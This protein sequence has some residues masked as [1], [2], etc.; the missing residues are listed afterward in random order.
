MLALLVPAEAV[1]A[2]SAA[3]LRVNFTEVAEGDSFLT[4]N[5][6]FTVVD[7]DGKVV[8]NASIQS[9]EIILLDDNSRYAAT[10]KKAD[11]PFYIVLVLDASGSMARAAADLRNAAAQSI[12]NAPDG[13]RFAVVMFNDKI[14]VLQDFTDDEERIANAI[15]KVIPVT[16]A[17]T[18]LYDA[19]YPAIDLLSQT[20]AGRRAV[21]VFT[22]GKD[23]TALRGPCSQ[24]T[25]NDVIDHA[26]EVGVGVPVNTIGLAANTSAINATEL[27]GM[28][29]STGGFAVVGSQSGLSEMFKEIMEALGNQW[30]A[31]GALYPTQGKHQAAI[32][33]TLKDGTKLSS[34]AAFESS[35]AYT[36]PANMTVDRV[37]Y[38]AANNIFK[39]S[40]NIGSPQLIDHLR[41]TVW[42]EEKGVQVAEYTV[43]DL[44]AAVTYDIK[45]DGFTSGSDYIFKISALDRNNNLVKN[46]E[47]QDI[48]LEHTVRYEPPEGVKTKLNVVS[49]VLGTQAL[50]ATLQVEGG[51]QV[52]SYEGWLN[53]D[54]NNTQVASTA[55]ALPG[56]PVNNALV[57]PLAGLAE[58]EYTIIVRAMGQNNTLL[59]QADYQGISYVPPAPP[60]EPS[61]FSVFSRRLMVGLQQNS[62]ILFAIIG[63][64]FLGIMG[65]LATVLLRRRETGTPVLQGRI[66]TNLA[67]DSSAAVN[68]TR[69]DMKRP[70]VA[71]PPPPVRKEPALI[72]L[73]VQATPDTTARGKAFTLTQAPF[74]IGREEGNLVL[75]EDRKVSRRHA[76]VSFDAQVNAYVVIDLGS[77]NGTWVNGQ[78]IPPNQPVRLAPG[79]V[80]GLGPD[81][82][83]VLEQK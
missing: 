50:T 80:I 66:E 70:V 46:S 49:V 1:R 63:F 28:A 33:I 7:N 5:V 60:P 21:I 43:R 79:A 52:V 41:I 12:T 74:I 14:N 23:E 57:I 3:S 30:M 27:E 45:T 47:G 75:K 56:M 6:Y 76:S 39:L 10:T 13:A 51:D 15:E 44:T 67:K 77:A 4:L 2:Q 22:D 54:E 64:I 73:R 83:L 11:T 9:A 29:S 19:T 17:G 34:T 59:A 32:Q 82:Q 42:D 58:G 37:I 38:E 81:T 68:V 25:F 20:P 61:A 26:N 36:V 24:H 69:M 72:L 55:F 65:V 62:W 16:N 18:C 48:Y 31:T 40:L 35:R 71:P 53:N 8:T 78:R